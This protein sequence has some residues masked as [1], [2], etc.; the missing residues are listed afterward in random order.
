MFYINIFIYLCNVLIYCTL[1]RYI[2]INIFLYFYIFYMY[3]NIL[4]YYTSFLFN[5][6]FLHFFKELQPHI[7]KRNVRK[8]RFWSSCFIEQFPPLRDSRAS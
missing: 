5:Y 6:T 3:N 4:I 7:L 8:F 2:K 1:Q